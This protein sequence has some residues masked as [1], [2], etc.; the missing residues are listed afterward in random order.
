MT[1]SESAHRRVTAVL[2]GVGWCIASFFVALVLLAYAVDHESI[3]PIALLALYVAGSGLATAVSAAR[4]WR[5]RRAK[6]S[7]ARAFER[8]ALIGC[9]A[10]FAPV[11]AALLW[12]TELPTNDWIATGTLLAMGTVL[13]VASIVCVRA[14]GRLD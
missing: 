5:G 12:P 9:A 13:A 11:A 3:G 6:R 14:V 2:L 8:L 7:K 4:L 10:A 1:A